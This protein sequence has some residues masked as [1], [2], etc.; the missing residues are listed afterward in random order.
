VSADHLADVGQRAGSAMLWQAMLHGSEKLI[1]LARLLI[2]AAILT[3]E[4][5]GLL[6]VSLVAVTVF[7]GLT[8]MG[9][10]LALIQRRSAEAVHYDTAWTFGVLRGLAVAVLVAAAAPWIVEP[11]LV[12][13]KGRPK[14]A[15]LDDAG[16][17]R[18]QHIPDRRVR[19]IH[20]RC[21]HIEILRLASRSKTSA[22]KMNDNIEKPNR[23]KFIRKELRNRIVS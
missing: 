3:P 14:L 12:D 1:D 10:T 4:D 8:E 21:V 5:F 18:F 7:T 11:G 20:S 22:Q 16:E 9:V 15:A 23:S 13:R 6:A 17:A 19:D 2:L